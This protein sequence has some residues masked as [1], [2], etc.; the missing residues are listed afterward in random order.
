[1]KRDLILVERACELVEMLGCGEV[2][3]GC[4]DVVGKERERRI[5]PFRPDYINSFLGTDIPAN[6]M[7]S[8]LEAIEFDVDIDAMTV[9]VPTFRPDVEGQADVAEEVARFYGYDVIPTTLLSGETTIGKKTTKQLITDKIN[10]LLADHGMY[11][12]YT[13]TFVSPTIYDKLRIPEDSSL[14]NNVVISNPLGEDTSVMRTTT[15]ANML[16]VLARNYKYKNEAVKFFE[17]GKIYVPT[18]PDKLPE[19][20]EMLTMGM[21][22]DTI[23][24]FDLKGM[25]EMLTEGLHISKVSYR[26]CKDNPIY[27]PGRTAEL[28]SRGKV[29]GILGQVHPETAENFDIDIPCYVAEID[30][31]KLID[32]VDD[33]IKYVQIPKFP[34]V[35]RDIAMLVDSDVPVAR[36]EEVMKKAGG[37]MLCSVKLFDVYQGKQIPEGKKSVAYSISFRDNTRS[38]TNEEVNVVFDKILKKLQ[39]EIDAQLR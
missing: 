33:D 17:I 36:I 9:S 28:I 4:I 1:M 26:A 12:I 7:V 25:C 29:I 10:A 24:F 13:Y 32:C 3:G 2:V 34:A 18:E 23:D 27:H 39:V 11:E 22:G 21:Y 15:V 31:N 38:L 8:Y 5:L 16:E 35:E 14:R 6:E 20:P 19:E 30:L 37:K